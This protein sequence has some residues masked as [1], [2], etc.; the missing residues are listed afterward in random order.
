MAWSGAR[1]CLDEGHCDAS[2]GSR[3]VSK[4]RAVYLL[5]MS[6][7]TSRAVSLVRSHGL[8]LVGC[9]AVAAFAYS[10]CRRAIV[11]SDEGYLLSQV[12]DMLAGKVLYRDMDAFVSP[13]I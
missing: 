2:I 8:A 10:V 12:V 9:A 6:E 13:G 7:R 4:L 1:P 5:A 3:L 11:I